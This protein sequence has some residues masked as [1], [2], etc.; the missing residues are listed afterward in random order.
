LQ[1]AA[2]HNI[3]LLQLGRLRHCYRLQHF[4]T[5]ARRFASRE[6]GSDGGRHRHL[7]LFIYIFY[8]YL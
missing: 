3:T 2:T 7:N 6:C 4:G 5:T 8:F 1:H